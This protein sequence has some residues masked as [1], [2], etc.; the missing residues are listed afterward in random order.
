MAPAAPTDFNAKLVKKKWKDQ[1]S[2]YLEDL[3][4]ELEALED[5]SSENVETAFK[6]FLEAKELGVWPGA[7]AVPHCVDGRRR[8]A[9]DV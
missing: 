4:S 2:G 1:T 3:A 8:G 6:A 5:F 9:V 7:V